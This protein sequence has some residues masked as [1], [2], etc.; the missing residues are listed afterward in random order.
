MFV[1][2]IRFEDE[3]YEANAI[4]S[5]SSYFVSGCKALI[6][7]GS[8][9]RTS[10]DF[11]WLKVGRLWNGPVF[12]RCWTKWLPFRVTIW[13]PDTL[14]RFLN[15][16][17]Q[18]GCL[19]VQNHLANRPPKSPVFKW[20]RIL[21]GRYSDPQCIHFIDKAWIATPIHRYLTGQLFS[22]SMCYRTIMFGRVI[23]ARR[24]CKARVLFVYLIHIL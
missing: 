9:N 7:W 23:Y 17:G 24:P 21:N 3:Y 18:N 20:F 11:K 14:F 5:D 19:F 1:L 10:S 12:E 4:F 22:S 8:K 13:K 6:Q 15:G 2:Q 16:F